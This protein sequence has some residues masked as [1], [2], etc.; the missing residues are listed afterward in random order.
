MPSPGA[1]VREF[2]HSTKA[3]YQSPAGAGIR[4]YPMRRA[5]PIMAQRIALS[6]PCVSS[7]CKASLQTPPLGVGP[8]LGELHKRCAETFAVDSQAV[9]KT[10]FGAKALK[11]FRQAQTARSV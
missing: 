1:T 8:Y 11:A 10:A 5:A 6:R 9:A 2:Q 3:A 7:W 4:T